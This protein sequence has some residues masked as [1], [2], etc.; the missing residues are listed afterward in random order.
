[1]VNGTVPECPAASL[2]VTVYTPG[3][4]DGIVNAASENE[5]VGPDSGLG[6]KATA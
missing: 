3:A 5:P 2:T 4:T 1:M 6:L